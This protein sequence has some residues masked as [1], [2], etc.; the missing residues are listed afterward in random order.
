MSTISVTSVQSK[1][2][3]PPIFKK[4]DGT[5]CGQLCVGNLNM[6]GTGTVAINQSFNVS[7]IADNG[8]GLYTVNFSNAYSDTGYIAVVTTGFTSTSSNKTTAADVRNMSTSSL[9][10][11]CEDVD[12]GFIDVDYVMIAVFDNV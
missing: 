5:K 12:A 1:N 11:Y 8:A 9:R 3:N 6:T 4:S 7:S 2:T 10:V